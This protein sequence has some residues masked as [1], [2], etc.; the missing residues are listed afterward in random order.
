[1]RFFKFPKEGLSDDIFEKLYNDRLFGMKEVLEKLINKVLKYRFVNIYG[2]ENCGKTRICLE[3]CK[4]FYMNNKFKDGI[5]YINLNKQKHINKHEFKLLKE[6]HGKNYSNKKDN[7]IKEIT[8]ALLV[9]DDF[10]LIK[11]GQQKKD[12]IKNNS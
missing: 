3:I 4:Y 2:D 8:D 5:F 9:F 6:K 12:G 1:M 10:D 7:K 11:K